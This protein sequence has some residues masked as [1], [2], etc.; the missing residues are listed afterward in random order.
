MKYITLRGKSS[1]FSFQIHARG[2]I[3]TII[4]MISLFV[5]SLASIS[6]G[7]MYIPI[8]DVFS[9][10]I[11]GVDNPTYEM[12]VM[13]LR[14]PRLLMAL[15][16]GASLGVAGLMLQAVIRNPLASP[17]LLGVNGGGSA[18]AVTFITL[19]SGSLSIHWLPL[20][21]ISGAMVTAILI[22]LFAWKDGISPYRLILIGL[23][24]STAAGS[25]TMYMLVAGPSFLATQIITWMTGSVYGL[26]MDYV[27]T[28]LPWFVVFMTLS[29]FMT[30]HLNTQVLGDATAS[31]VGQ[32]VE[33]YRLLILFISVALAGSA[34]G[35]SGPIAFVGL[36]AP[37]IARSLIGPM[38]G[39]L[40]PLSASIGA[41]LLVGADYIGRLLF[42]P[43]EI[44]AGVFTA[45]LG[46]P[47]FIYLLL[48]NRKQL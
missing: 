7:S 15:M 13:N 42:Q 11:L 45:V 38:H 25:I 37:H 14:L 21:A 18:A 3:I 4:A 40:I 30:R 32:S 17:E 6:F 28:L 5:L 20:V 43:T 36:I 2:L 27:W 34:V 10:L 23:G 44:P 1:R 19:T 35:M 39:W 22:Y 24:I 47:F 12:V 29:F 26:S 33:R 41:M 9:V 16:I 48:Q 31:S 8:K 46:A